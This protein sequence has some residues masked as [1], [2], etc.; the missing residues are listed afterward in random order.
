[1]KRHLW[2][3]VLWASL[4][5]AEEG[6]WT[7]DAFPA[8]AVKKA[9]GFQ[10][11]AAWLEKV[12]LSSVRLAGGCSASFVSPRG[13]V[14][15]N[16]H[17]VRSCIQQLS[18]SRNDLLGNGFYARTGAQERQC[19]GVEANQLVETRDVTSR[20][21]AATQGKKDADYAQA[22][23]REQ[24][25]I[26]A[27]CARS[28]E[29]RCDL[30]SLFEGARYHL[31]RYRRFQ[32]VR[33]VFAPE[34]QMAAFGGYP[35][36]F[37]FPR[38]GFDAAFLRIYEQGQPVASPNFFPWSTKGASEGEL[39]FSSGHPGGTERKLSVADLEAQRDVEVPWSLLLLSEQRAVLRELLRHKPGLAPVVQARLRSIENSHKALIGRH[40]ALSEPGFFT[41][42]REEEAR[43]RQLIRLRFDDWEA[44]LAAFDQVAQALQDY[45]GF[46]LEHR[47]LE[48]ADAFNSELFGLAR[49]LL[50]S[51]RERQ[52]PNPER[53]REYTDAAWPFTVHKLLAE[54]PVS[55]PLE[56]A[57]LIN[58]LEK[59]REKLGADHPA[60]TRI[61]GEETP[62]QLAR[63]VLYGTRLGD[64][65]VRKKLMEGGVAAVE[66]SNDPMLQLARRVDPLAR[67][68]RTRFQE[69]VE[70]VLKQGRERIAQAKIQ[71][72]GLDSYPDATFTLRLSYGQVKG[73]KG[74]IGE[75]P[76]FTTFQGAREHA[77]GK[78]PFE[79]AATWRRGLSRVPPETPLNLV[80]TN[81]IIGGNSG[82]PLIN[83]QA[84]I[85]GLIFDGNL[86]S[87][88]GRFY[89][90]PAENRAVAVDARGLLAGLEHLYR[91]QRLVDELRGGANKP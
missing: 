74:P 2:L 50:R 77:T 45:H 91:A 20:V 12:R 9:H 1:M 22:F 30:V 59:L 69:R 66:A 55:L 81:D 38:Y 63:R 29:D 40:E 54:R 57:L 49:E 35:D 88:G 84:E 82:S 36:N 41:R 15:T 85:V 4:A 8:E 3:G 27:E 61:L 73:W 60:V 78:Y 39:V 56:E 67:L 75:V 31:Y 90:D 83:R 11:D 51:S 13:L 17:C 33:L 42:R 26:E 21:A 62:E 79:L 89:Y 34:F 6:M 18:T 19:P 64:D 32:D 68:V 52:K 14:M 23:K 72:E 65:R 76:A 80:T 71:A 44:T 37:N 25:A 86:P 28:A 47:L 53:L 43:L 87:L 58:S 7:F 24:T 46:R 10:P 70:P 16:H 5:V 48:S